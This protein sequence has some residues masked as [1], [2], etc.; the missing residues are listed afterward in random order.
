MTSLSSK[1]CGV[2]HGRP[3]PHGLLCQDIEVV[4]SAA[5]R[6]PLPRVLERQHER[7]VSHHLHHAVVGHTPR[8]ALLSAAGLDPDDGHAFAGVGHRRRQRLGADA[9]NHDEACAV[10]LE[11]EARPTRLAKLRPHFVLEAGRALIAAIFCGGGGGLL[12]E[13]PALL[14]QVQLDDAAA[15]PQD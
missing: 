12:D 11:V 14:Q 8:L 10:L 6:L 9:P 2:T 1:S 13:A 5:V 7:P 3:I 15:C 4:R